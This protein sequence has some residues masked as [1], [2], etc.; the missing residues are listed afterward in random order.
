MLL[1][2]KIEFEDVSSSYKSSNNRDR[3]VESEKVPDRQFELEKAAAKTR[4]Y[5]T[6]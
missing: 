1:Q 3:T 5:P 2:R 4:Q 6:D